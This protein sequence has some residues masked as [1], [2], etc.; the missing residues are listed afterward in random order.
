M[1][2]SPTISL[3]GPVATGRFPCFDG[4][5]AIAALSVVGVHV[6]FVSGFTGSSG[7]GIYTSRLEIG[8]SIFFV[9]SG[10]LLYRPFV[11]GHLG[12]RP[13]PDAANFWLRRLVR[14]VP[15]YWLAFVVITYV[16]QADT[17]PAH[18]WSPLVYLG[19]AQIYVPSLATHGISQAW[20]LCTEMTFYLF[21]PLWGWSM[22]T[23][24]RSTAHQLRVELGGLAV[25]VAISFGFRLW[26]LNHPSGLARTMPDWLPAYLDLFALGMLLAVISAWVAVRG[27]DIAWLCGSWMPWVSWA[28]A[29]AAFVA[30]SHLGIPV[31][32]IYHLPVATNLA[33]QTLYGVFA[34]LLVLPAVIGP[35]DSGAIRW[36]LRSRPMM[37]VGIISYGIYLW[38]Q[39]ALTMVLRVTDNQLFTMPWAELLPAVVF[40]AAVVAALSYRFVE[41]PAQ[42]WAHRRSVAQRPAEHPPAA[43]QSSGRTDRA[44]DPT[45]AQSGVVR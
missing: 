29:G 26:C 24:A 10:F 28:L 15:A 3:R 7:L 43:S 31:I 18:W 16:A 30:V 19:F 41:R 36:F 32:P 14:I 25:L 5:R 2:G 22:A 13:V 9:I 44:V 27:R 20:T 38:H 33:R 23:R 40:C 37:A 21:L 34:F 45:P 4:L 11:L 8:V 39:A 1:R 35:S 42:R 6:A 17:V 12:A